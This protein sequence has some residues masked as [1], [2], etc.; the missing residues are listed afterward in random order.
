MSWKRKFEGA[1]LEDENRDPKRGWN[2]S[3]V[4]QLA[5]HDA[6]A[7]SNIDNINHNGDRRTGKMDWT[8]E[9]ILTED[10]DIQPDRNIAHNSEII[11]YGALCDANVKLARKQ[12]GGLHV[13]SWEPFR[14]LRVFKN[15]SHYNIRCR[16]DG[17]DLGILDIR[18]T[19]ILNP[20]QK[21]SEV[22]FTAVIPAAVFK[23]PA[24]KKTGHAVVSDVSVN[25][26]GP[27]GLLDTVG[28]AI[29]NKQ[30][31]LQHPYSLPAGIEYLNP[32]YFYPRGIRVNL[33]N[34]VG[35]RLETPEVARLAQG[36]GDVFNS[37]AHYEYSENTFADLL[38]EAYADGLIT[39]RLQRHQEVGVNLMLVR[40]ERDVALSAI[41]TI[42]RVIGPRAFESHIPTILGGIDADV[43]GLGKTL[44]MLSAIVCTMKT[45]SE[46]GALNPEHSSVPTTRATLVV[47][48]SPQVLMET[49]MSEI[50]RHLKP[51]HLSLCV[52]HGKN[53][54]KVVGGFINNDVVLTTYRTL[55]SDWKARGLLQKVMWFRVVLDEA[56]LIRNST[57]QQ[58]KAACSLAAQRKWC[59]TGTPIQNSLHDL[60][61]LLEFLDFRPFS[62]PSFFRK[63]IL[64]PLHEDS[65][66][67]FRNLKALMRITCFRRTS[68]LLL[69]PQASTEEIAIELTKD[70][71]QS[72]ED[73]LSAS[74][75][76]YDTI[77]DMRSTRKKYC[78]LFATTMKLRR[79]CNHGTFVHS[80]SFHELLSPNWSPRKRNTDKNSSE[81]KLPCA[82][83]YDDAENFSMYG[84][85]LEVCPECSRVLDS[86]A[87]RASPAATSDSG[88]N[89][90][91]RALGETTRPIQPPRSPLEL[92]SGVSSKLNAVVD[93]ILGSLAISK[94]L[95]FASWRDTLDIL[96]YLLAQ[97]GINCLRMDGRTSFTDRHSILTQFRRDTTQNVL[98]L[99]IATGSVGLTLTVAD[100]VHI[101]E[102][103]WNP[104]VEE[105]AIGRAVRMGQDRPV[106]I[107]KYIT[108][109]S[110]EQN[111][112]T[113]QKRK[114]QLVKISLDACAGDQVQ[115]GLEVLANS[116]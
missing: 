3:N 81:E 49:W 109:N 51:G 102:P 28:E 106:K 25:I 42:Q 56:H 103:Q 99:S 87:E 17:V 54:P 18:V 116:F 24:K 2:R 82:Y 1:E 72:Y 5:I 10:I 94:H 83:C 38:N 50:E 68:E 67:P 79:L 73:V 98:L 90:P 46:F 78:L 41:Q 44:T 93:N 57:S 6:S 107:Y 11:C 85:T 63:H 95:V 74:K 115:Q 62:E 66:E 61:S 32:H 58:F 22:H 9:C 100:R 21:W 53:K 60:R 71:Q 96:Q 29:T 88:N 8:S 20:L 65:P 97:R 37:L 47:T 35:P 31:H 113:L 16:N 91:G 19:D 55:E 26:L 33:R 104:F 12:L 86:Q 52:F 36:L 80:S 114:N 101:V 110:V 105:Q 84:T 92:A 43:M 34:L 111:I 75:K 112:V 45:A 70:E 89:S 13:D 27:R 76:E 59:L 64:E 7:P 48:S 77:V 14:E 39:T 23:A 40:E 108:K 4:I 15:G 69:L 30:G